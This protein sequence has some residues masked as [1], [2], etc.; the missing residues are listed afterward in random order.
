MVLPEVALFPHAM[1]PLF[2]FEEQYRRML[3]DALNGS[4]IFCVAQALPDGEARNFRQLGGVGLIRACVGN[5]D[6]SSH[7]ILQGL[8]RVRFG[9]L[10]ANAPYRF[11]EIEPVESVIQ[12]SKIANQL[13]AELRRQCLN[14]QDKGH[15]LPAAL[16]KALDASIPAGELADLTAAA[17]VLGGRLGQQLLEELCVEERL[18]CLLKILGEVLDS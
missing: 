10:H 18:R 12:D 2:I 13:S 14:L 15:Q 4:R 9:R 17:F 7:L 16:T 11:S 8:S 5:P 3:E 1:L 6:G